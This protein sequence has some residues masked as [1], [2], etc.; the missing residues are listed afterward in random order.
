MEP[1]GKLHV[2]LRDVTPADLDALTS[3]RPPRALHAERMVLRGNVDDTDKRYVLAEHD[4]RP[5]GFGL[6]YFRGDA[7]WR[8]PDRVPLMMD[9]FVAPAVRGRGAGSSIV[10]FLEHSARARG[11]P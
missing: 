8:R 2:V 3:L 1:A 6:I 5:V 9:L 11:F 4:G 7:A 10:R